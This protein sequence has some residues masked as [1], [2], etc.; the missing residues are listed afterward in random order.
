VRSWLYADAWLRH[1]PHRINRRGRLVPLPPPSGRFSYR[2]P[3]LYLPLALTDLAFVRGSNLSFDSSGDYLVS[4]D[5]S[6]CTW[7]TLQIQAF[8]AVLANM[9]ATFPQYNGVD[10]SALGHTSTATA[11][12]SA[13]RVAY[14]PFAVTSPGV[15]NFEI[16]WTGGGAFVVS[17]IAG[18]GT[19]DAA[20]IDATGWTQSEIVS[21][22]GSM[23]PQVYTPTADKAFPIFGCYDGSGADQIT[24]TSGCTKGVGNATGSMQLFYCPLSTPAGTATSA[25]CADPATEF[26]LVNF[27]ALKP[28]GGA[29]PT[30]GPECFPARVQP[31]PRQWTTIVM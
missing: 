24:A 26:V 15:H 23:T 7:G 5:T 16:K 22:S 17:A 21:G 9:A 31:D 14:Y 20:V 18:S 3:G 8:S 13:G 11:H 27:I 25:V 1:A 29:A 2:E 6:G 4:F 12:F 10:I 30:F 28:A 19:L